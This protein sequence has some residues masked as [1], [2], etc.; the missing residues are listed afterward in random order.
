VIRK[1]AW[2][3]VHQGVATG[4]DPFDYRH[5]RNRQSIMDGVLLFCGLFC[6]YRRLGGVSIKYSENHSSQEETT[7]NTRKL[8]PAPRVDAA[9]PTLNIQ[10]HA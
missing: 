7:T 2:L 9:L 10:M 5:E 4:H 6:L 3:Y 1:S 8:P